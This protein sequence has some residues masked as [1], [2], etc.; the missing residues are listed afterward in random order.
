MGQ[1]ANA[2]ETAIYLDMPPNY[3]LEKKG[4]KE[5]FL[6]T[7]G[8]E[9]LRLI[10]VVMLAA[11][12]EG[13]KLPTLLIL[14]RKTLPKSEAFPKDVI[15]RAQEEGWMTEEVMLEWLKIVWGRRPRNQP[16][17]LILDTFKGHLTNSVKNQLRK[18]KNE[19]VVMPGGMTS[20]LQPMDVSIIK[21]FKD[22][23]RQQYLT[24]IA[25]PA[26][27]LTETGKIKRTAP[28]EVARWVS[29]A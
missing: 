1:M 9:N 26:P 10:L 29:A 8:C 6:K 16:S 14:K 17:M 5:V 24:W 18:M 19:L 23:S 15:V 28:S 3:T 11:T 27:E 7:T 22:R 4:V 21:P 25:D 13:R 20:V 12:A 2:D